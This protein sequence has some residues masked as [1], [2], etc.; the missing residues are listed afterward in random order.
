V[1]VGWVV[2]PA[3]VVDPAIDIA[4]KTAKMTIAIVETCRAIDFIFTDKPLNL[5][6]E[7]QHKTGL[8]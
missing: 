4:T 5:K 1:I 2:T 6:F 3:P 8:C 7:R